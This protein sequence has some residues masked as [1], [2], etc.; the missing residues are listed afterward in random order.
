MLT[1]INVCKQYAG[2]RQKAFSFS[3][4]IA[5]MLTICAVPAGAA[6]EKPSVLQAKTILKPE[7]LK[8]KN[9]SV[10]DQVKNDGLFNHYI[11]ESKFGSFQA[12]ST[13]D[14]KILV[15]EIAAIAAMKQVATDDTVKAAL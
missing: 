6:Y 11:V 15:S 5:F 8:N 13:K 2:I 3:M 9:Y 14:L 1:I 12:G 7:L 4:L 10:Q